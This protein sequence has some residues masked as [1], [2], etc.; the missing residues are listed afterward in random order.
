[1]A[2]ATHTNY[3]P[4]SNVWYINKEYIVTSIDKTKPTGKIGENQWQT[5]T[6]SNAQIL[7]A[8]RHEKN[9]YSYSMILVG[10]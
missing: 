5:Q 7:H 6:L 10:K 2:Q 8:K 1:M 3:N 4:Q 9:S